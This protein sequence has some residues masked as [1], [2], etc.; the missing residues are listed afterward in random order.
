MITTV[1]EKFD[2]KTS[3]TVSSELRLNEQPQRMSSVV[4]KKRDRL[5]RLHEDIE[6]KF[7]K[8]TMNQTYSFVRN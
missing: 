1:Y 6:E 5:A 2:E 7:N 8:S 4:W 3:E